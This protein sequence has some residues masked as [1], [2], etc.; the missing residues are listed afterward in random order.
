MSEIESLPVVCYIVRN[1]NT[2]EEYEFYLFERAE[3][4]IKEARENHTM[5]TWKMFVEIDA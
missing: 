2:G 5:A 1:M 4:F 3:R